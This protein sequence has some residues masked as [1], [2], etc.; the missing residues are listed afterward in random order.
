MH[1]SLLTILLLSTALPIQGFAQDNTAP[2]ATQKM[3][4]GVTTGTTDDAAATETNATQQNAQS[5]TATQAGDTFVT[6]PQ[7][8]AWRVSD[9]EGK[10]VYSAEGENIGDIKDVLVNKDGTVTAVLI[11]VGGF[12]GIGEKDVAVSMTA[13]EFGPGMTQSEADAAAQRSKNPAV[14]NETTAATDGTQPSDQSA[15]APATDPALTNN[16]DA[17]N[18]TTAP[19]DQA[20]N[21]DPAATQDN[22]AA[23]NMN[24]NQQQMASNAGIAIGNDGLPDRIV[25]NVT[26]EELENAPAFPG[27]QAAQ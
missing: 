8:G 19:S 2:A 12:L 18:N 16:T 23:Q 27:V 21:S 11:G 10:P 9:L 17:L 13:L 15:I 7:N 24:A 22:A 4:Q 25:L 14:S 20:Q 5:A 26:R 3:D 6:V 1:K